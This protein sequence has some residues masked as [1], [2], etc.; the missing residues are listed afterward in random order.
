MKLKTFK[1]KICMKNKILM[2]LHQNIINNLLRMTIVIKDNKYSKEQKTVTIS[3]VKL[4][5]I[6]TI[7]K[8]KL[9]KMIMETQ[10]NNNKTSTMILAEIKITKKINMIIISTLSKIKYNKKTKT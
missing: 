10:K 8:V 7:S 4:P 2:T 3:K 1:V 5:K 9:Q 6:I